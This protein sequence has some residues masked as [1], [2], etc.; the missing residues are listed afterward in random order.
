MSDRQLGEERAR[1]TINRPLA[2][3]SAFLSGL[4]SA[5]SIMDARSRSD[6]SILLGIEE[7]FAGLVS[8]Y[9]PRQYDKG[10]SGIC[11]VAEN[12]PNYANYAGNIP[13]QKHTLCHTSV[14]PGYFNQMGGRDL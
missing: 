6:K 12:S 10:F 4:L 5:S 8:Q 2:A 14:A 3:F 7:G 11:S 9:G 1:P 13:S